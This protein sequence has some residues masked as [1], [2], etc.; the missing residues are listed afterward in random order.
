MADVQNGT[1]A[2]VSF[3]MWCFSPMELDFV[4]PKNIVN[5][6]ILLELSF[7]GEC[8]AWTQSLLVWA[9]ATDFRMIGFRLSGEKSRISSFTNVTQPERNETLTVFKEIVYILSYNTHFKNLPFLFANTT[10]VWPNLVEIDLRNNSIKGIPAQWK[11]TMPLL[12]TLDLAYNNLTEPP[13]FPWN[14]STLEMFRGLR[15]TYHTDKQET[16]K[17]GVEVRRSLYIRGLYLGY[18]NI[19]DL[20][21]HKFRGFL[22]LLR[23]PDNGLKTIGPSC[24]HGLQGVQTIDLS[25]N[26][27]K[28]VPENLFQ[29]L[30]SLLNI[31][32][33]KNNIAV[34]AQKLFKGLEKI[35]RI[36]LDHNNLNA[37]PDGVFNSLNT[38]EVLHLD[39]NKITKLG[40][41]PF[42]QQ[43]TLRELYLQNNNLSSIPS[44]IFGLNKIEVIDLSFNQLTFEDLDKALEDLD[45]P[46]GDPLENPPIV[47]N[48]ENNNITT[49][50]DSTGLKEIKLPLWQDKYT[51]LWKAFVIKLTG[52]PLACDC[53]MFAVAKQIRKM[54][55]TNPGM[56]LRFTT[57]KCNWPHQLQHKLVLEIEENQWMRQEEPDNCPD[58]C[59][60]LKRCFDGIIVVDCEKKSLKEVPSSMPQGLIELN[61]QNNKIKD[62][63]AHPYLIN[64]TVLK[65]SN[66]KVEQLQASMV[67]KLKHIKIFLIDSNK[68]SSLPKEI[69]VLN[70]TTLAIDQNLFKCDCTTKWMKPWLLKNKNRIRN[71]ERV[72]CSSEHVL[73]H[74]MFN[75][76]DD[77]F[78]CRTP[79]EKPNSNPID[80]NKVATATV[81][82]ASI[83]GSLLLLIAVAVTVL[84]MK[85]HKKVKVFMFSRFNWHPFDR[86]YDS[87]R[88]KIYDAFVSFSDD[89]RQWVVN[90]LQERLENH[91]PPYKLCI[92]HRD[93]HVGATIQ[94]NILASVDQSKRML[95]VLSHRSITSEWCLLEFRAAHHKV[96]EHR[97]NYLIIILFDDVDVAELDEEMQLYMCTNNYVSVGDKWFWQKLF[98]AMPQ[99]ST[100][101]SVEERSTEL[102]ERNL[103]VETMQEIERAAT[104]K[105]SDKILL[106]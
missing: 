21:S 85:Y 96:L 86:T 19:I 97:M 13:E 44:W 28:S 42:P 80:Q 100:R 93:F 106:V 27:L 83:L 73:G 45:V 4:N 36:Y 56:R 61:L 46:I 32:L 24:F 48:L 52:N 9:K 16:G 92:H 33:G 25:R 77:K 37:I 14:N 88:N 65:L 11:T 102:S 51:Y 72:L 89:A 103:E 29:G 101:E 23:L 84:Y 34:I 40:D 74:A 75:L 79:T 62:I 49:L 2:E 82:V 43:S 26:E 22:H 39:A 12:Q 20:S 38:L 58:K 35:K 63:P 53:I 60:C 98:Y 68:L 57:W 78:I 31:H 5:K 10:N 15:R 6:D 95:M 76:S 8:S 47:L 55:E 105:V 54:L 17:D 94:D 30:S 99:H 71:F 1:L 64:V 69:E 104:L 66:N 3:L 59:F 50:I 81:I 18:N 41:D 67:Q 91:N 70:F 90:T 7:R 87:D